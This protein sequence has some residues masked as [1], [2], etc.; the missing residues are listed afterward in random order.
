MISSIFQD[1]GGITPNFWNPLGVILQFLDEHHR[2]LLRECSPFSGSHSWCKQWAQV[3]LRRPIDETGQQES[4]IIL[5][6][7]QRYS[8]L[9]LAK[10]IWFHAQATVKQDPCVLTLSEGSFATC[11]LIF[12]K[13]SRM[14]TAQHLGIGNCRL[15]Y[16]RKP[17]IHFI[18]ILR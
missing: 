6:Q 3:R 17:L 11:P 5:V 1:L 7:Q 16:R 13:H 9:A 2:Q 10:H 4:S 18:H 12:V 14:E 15:S 8:W